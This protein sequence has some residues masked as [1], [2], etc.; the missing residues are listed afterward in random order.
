MDVL[1]E[2]SAVNAR[3]KKREK[4][5]KIVNV[6][7]VIFGVLTAIFAM[8]VLFSLIGMIGAKGEAK[9]YGISYA[10]SMLFPALFF[11]GLFAY[12]Y[13]L[14]RR[15]N[16]SY[17]YTF[18]SGELRIARVYNTN[19]RKFLYRIDA[20]EM[21]QIGD[22]DSEGFDRLVQKDP[23]M[24]RIVCTPNDTPMEGKFFLYLQVANS[25]GRNLYIL[26]CREEMLVQILHFAKRGTLASDYVEQS[27]KQ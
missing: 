10:V 3:A 16:V 4:I 27:K 14:K 15:L 17:D 11:G 6:F 24:K 23:S 26:E 25:Y 20:E 22:V 2:E 8:L 9:S 18:V 12:T 1:Y 5:Y 19:K 21:M 7:S 13:F